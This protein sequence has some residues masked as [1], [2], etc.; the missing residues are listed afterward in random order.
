M[1]RLFASTALVPLAALALAAVFFLRA[2]APP[3]PVPPGPIPQPPVVVTQVDLDDVKPF[4]RYLPQSLDWLAAAQFSNGGWGAGQHA[5]QGIDDPH[6][7]QMDPATTAFAA[8]AL[9]RTGSTP[10][11]GPYAENVARALAYLLDLVEESSE[12]GP[13]ITTI[14]GTQPQAKLGR[15]IDAAMVA[16][17]FA[18]ILPALDGRLER[19]TEAALDK[20]LRKIQRG[21]T[22]D[23]SWDD[24]GWA[25]VLQS[26]M[27]NS[28]LESAARAGRDVDEDV[29]RRSREYQAGNI[30]VRGGRADPSAPAAEVDASAGAGVA[31]YAASSSQRATAE[32]ARKA[33]DLIGGEGEVSVDGLRQAGQSQEEAE[34][35]YDAYRRNEATTELLDDEGIWSGFGNNGGEEFLSYMMT[36]ESLV[37]AGGPA[38]DRWH[39]RLSNLF[40]SIQNDNGSWSGHHCITSPVFSTAAVVLALTADRD[41]TLLAHE[42][43][44]G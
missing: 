30:Q 41:R 10:D 29:L 26:A 11:D 34:R 43:Q 24:G 5:Q 32:E 18:A 22:A 40:G 25:P 2:P 8:L 23:G 36:S 44:R 16:Q 15:N 39:A 12:D 13:R 31:L 1:N 9:M 17:F 7:V 14:D 27:A 21:Q 42:I 3:D 28:A 33:Q 20:C 37:I 35:L 38:W 6:A 4:P 19:R